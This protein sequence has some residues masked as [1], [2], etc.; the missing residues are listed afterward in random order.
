M[1]VISSSNFEA[2]L[3]FLLCSSAHRIQHTAHS[4]QHTA[5][6]IQGTAYRIQH[7]GYITQ[8]TAYITQHTA[9]IIQ[10]TAY[11]IQHT[12]YSTHHTSQ[13]T[14]DTVYSQRMTAKLPDLDL[15][16]MRDFEYVY[17]PSDDT[18]LLCDALEGDREELTQSRPQIILEIGYV[19][20]RL[21]SLMIYFSSV[22]GLHLQRFFSVYYS[23]CCS[24]IICPLFFNC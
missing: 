9:H 13:Q 23:T 24:V 3:Y 8:P 16:N 14:G 22:G 5:Y 15:L 1:Q 10:H 12:A 11:S 19:Y 20:S 18:F 4:L 2:L 21:K 6:S 7:T 17:E